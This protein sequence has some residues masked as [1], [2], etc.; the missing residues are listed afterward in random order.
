[1]SNT[2][3]RVIVETVSSLIDRNGNRH[4]FAVFYNPAK[5]RQ[6]SV[7]I[8]VGGE[9]NARC[10]AYKLAGNDHEGTLAFEHSLGKRDWQFQRANAK[11][12]S[13]EGSPEAKAALCAL[14]DLK[15]GAL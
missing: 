1:M 10:I 11:P 14:F 13:Y 7:A 5:G 6:H 2:P 8:E 3:T 15:G 4:H 12:I 9:S